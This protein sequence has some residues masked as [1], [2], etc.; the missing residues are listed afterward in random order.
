MSQL[1]PYLG[2]ASLLLVVA[3]LWARQIFLT[4]RS[5][6]EVIVPRKHQA[7]GGSTASPGDLGE[8][9]FGLEDWDFVSRNM[10]SEIHKM[11]LRERA[12]LAI[13][14]LRRTRTRISL[15]MRTHAAAVGQIEDLH[16][17]T[18]LKLAL[19]YFVFLILCDLLIAWIWLH[20]PVRTRKM[21]D[22]T[23]RTVTWLRGVFEQLMARTDP[24]TCKTLRTNLD[25]RAV[26]G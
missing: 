11:F 25:H 7:A 5:K 22:Q 12:T 24:A 14:W 15:V 16:L 6:I 26:R 21:V 23:L 13:S 10:S 18:E 19:N 9:I 2:V 4:R 8:R 1:L 17:A 20:G 3:V